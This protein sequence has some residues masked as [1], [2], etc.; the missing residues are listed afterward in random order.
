[1]NRYRID[2]WDE[3]ETELQEAAEWYEIR[4]EGLGADLLSEI[5]KTLDRVQDAPLRYPVIEPGVRRA[6]V[7][8]FPFNLIFRVRDQTIEILAFFHQAK[9]PEQWKERR[10]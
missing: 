7:S 5:D 6:I 10:R 4:K 3:A 2:I 8:R 1:M 9:D